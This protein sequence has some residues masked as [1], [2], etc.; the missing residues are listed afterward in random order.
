MQGR[1]SHG[2]SAPVHRHMRVIAA[3][4]LWAAT[5]AASADVSTCD[6]ENDPCPYA[7]DGL[8]DNAEFG[9]ENLHSFL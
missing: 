2:L 5:P 3:L 6:L 9:G 7:G 8:C 4:V 1:A